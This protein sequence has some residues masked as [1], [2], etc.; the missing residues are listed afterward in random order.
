MARWEGQDLTAVERPS[1]AIF[2]EERGW[3]HD[4]HGLLFTMVSSFFDESD[5]ID[6]MHLYANENF[7][8]RFKQNRALF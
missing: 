4:Q 7:A 3:F 5:Q 1:Q 2:D 8:S 6:G